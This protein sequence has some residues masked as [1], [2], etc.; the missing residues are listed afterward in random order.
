M[1]TDQLSYFQWTRQ[2][3]PLG[4]QYSLK[5]YLGRGLRPVVNYRRIEF[6]R[7][8]IQAKQQS[9]ITMEMLGYKN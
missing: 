6:I 9:R 1:R 2:L 5:E 7:V 3:A 4:V 8:R